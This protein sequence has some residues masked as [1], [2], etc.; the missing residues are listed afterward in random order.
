M[1][2]QREARDGGGG[3]HTPPEWQDYFSRSPKCTPSPESEWGASGIFLCA[4]MGDGELDAWLRRVDAAIQDAIGEGFVLKNGLLRL[5]SGFEVVFVDASVAQVYIGSLGCGIE[6]YGFREAG[7]C[8]L[9][10]LSWQW[11][12]RVPAPW[13][14][15]AVSVWGGLAPAQGYLRR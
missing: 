2:V 11:L 10:S 1:P 9:D 15:D 7:A 3:L 12:A 5:D 13:E 14:W 6:V 8:P 4:D